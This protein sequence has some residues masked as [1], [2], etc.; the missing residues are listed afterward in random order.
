MI[1][2]NSQIRNSCCKAVDI[3][4]ASDKNAPTEKLFKLSAN[5]VSWLAFDIFSLELEQCNF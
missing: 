5:H 2:K 4:Q 3:H 1:E